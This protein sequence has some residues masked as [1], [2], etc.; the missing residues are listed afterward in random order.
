M[1]VAAPAALAALKGSTNKSKV[2][3]APKW[4]KD[5]MEAA[6]KRPR[7]TA[8]QVRKQWEA[9]AD[10]RR[11]NAH[12]PR[13][14]GYTGENPPAPENNCWH[15]WNAHFDRNQTDEARKLLWDAMDRH[16]GLQT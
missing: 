16:D 14:V 10:F 4:L 6:Q 8:E 3:S 11:K 15:C 7:P 9:S 13:H 12:C 2:S 1:I 5:Q